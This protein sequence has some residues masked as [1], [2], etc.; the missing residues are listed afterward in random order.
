MGR[1][2]MTTPGVP[3][4]PATAME[5]RLDASSESKPAPF[6]CCVSGG[7]TMDVHL[8]FQF[9]QPYDPL[10]GHLSPFEWHL[11]SGV[12]QKHDGFP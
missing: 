8:L 9:Q 1:R 3:S 12:D 10:A 5:D 2:L 11:K 6:F 4:E 7:P